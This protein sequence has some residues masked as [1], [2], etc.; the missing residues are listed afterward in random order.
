MEEQAE[1]NVYAR[2]HGKIQPG[3]EAQPPRTERTKITASRIDAFQHSA[4]SDRFLVDTEQRGLRLKVTPSNKRVWQ[5]V[6]W[7]A[8]KNKTV[9]V[10]VGNYPDLSPKRAR[11]IAQDRLTEIASG[12]N[13]NEEKRRTKSEGQDIR[14]A[15]ASLITSSGKNI[16]EN[17]RKAYQ[18]HIDQYCKAL[19][20]GPWREISVSDVNH[21]AT[22]LTAQGL[23]PAT[24]SGILRSLH[25]VLEHAI[26][27]SGWKGRNPVHSA[28]KGNKNLRSVIVARDTSISPHD[29]PRWW[30]ALLQ[31]DQIWQDYLQFL[32]LTGMRR[33]EATALR[34]EHIE[35]LGKHD[36]YQIRANITLPGKYTKANRPLLLPVG[37]F[38]TRLLQRRR[39]V[40][41]VLATPWVF[42]SPATKDGSKPVAE[43]K[44]ACSRIAKS[45]GVKA[46]PHD[47]RRT[48]VGVCDTLDMPDGVT[49]RLVNHSV[50]AGVT[51]RHCGGWEH[52]RLRPHMERIEADI[53]RRASGK[54]YLEGF[55]ADVTAPTNVV[56]IGSVSEPAK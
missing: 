12:M 7:F 42:W 33:R 50:P 27:T 6:K 30:H 47:L 36:R 54:N 31:E 23:A 10:T 15:A 14:D 4:S 29:L 46:S 28:R 32:L 39:V 13:P 38:L 9:T 52:E 43:P 41:A 19:H 26:S 18:R 51:S 11:L 55:M 25:R 44:K 35:R 21:L 45:S 37:P 2:H 3:R 56:D 8:N 5:L 24:I 49:K 20:G 17:T 22:R 53:L 1:T 16:S 40:A 48:F 34:W